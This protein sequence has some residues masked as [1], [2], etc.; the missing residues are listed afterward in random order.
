[1]NIAP[2]KPGTRSGTCLKNH[3]TEL[4]TKNSKIA[5]TTMPELPDLEV[6]SRNITKV[7]KGKKLV[8]VNVVQAKKLNVS[9]AEFKDALQGQVLTEV[10]RSG[11]QLHFNFKDGSVLALHLMLHGKLFWFEEKNEN[12]F[13]IIEMHFDGGKSLALTDF[14]RQATPTLNPEKPDAPDALDKEANLEFWKATLHKSKSAVKSI[15]MDQ[16]VIQGIGNAY[17]DEILYDARLSPFSVA[18][19]IPDDQIKV[20]AKSV[21]NVLQDAVKEIAKASP[22]IISGEVR[23]FL[24]VHRPKSDTTPS[25]ATIHQKTLSSRKTYYTDEQQL[26]K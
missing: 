17:A 7:L 20:L 25:G 14:Q 18:N 23:E 4:E 19:K 24:K 1:M 16:H 5:L 13:T 3:L 2:P 15:I 12:K 21:K 6:F 10:I 22:D 26:Y 9:E 8:K 11:K